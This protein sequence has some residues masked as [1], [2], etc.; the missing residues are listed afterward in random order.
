MAYEDPVRG[1]LFTAALLKA[2]Q[3]VDFAHVTYEGL[4]AESEKILK[5]VVREIPHK[6]ILTILSYFF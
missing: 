1:G 3:Y 2:A 4:V 6:I 5:C